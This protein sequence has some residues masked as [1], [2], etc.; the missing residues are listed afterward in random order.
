MATRN[1]LHISKL[2]EFEDF[3]ETKGYMIVATSKNPYEVLRAQK[4]SDTVIVYQKKDAKEHLSTMDKDY[5]LVREFIKEQRKQS[6]ADRI[7]GMTDEELAKFISE[8][9][10]CNICEQF[11][12]RLDRCGADNHFV[13][14]KEYA[15][16]IIGDWLNKLVEE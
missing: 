11:D 6:N 12:K 14:V 10:A 1:I 5:R 15:E 13:C 9:S 4:D 8:F 16:A 3:L 2:Q 7:R